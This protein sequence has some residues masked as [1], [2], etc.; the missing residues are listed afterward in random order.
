MIVDSATL[1]PPPPALPPSE[2]LAENLPRAWTD[3]TA[4]GATI[5]AQLSEKAGKPLPWVTVR[6]AIDGALRMRIVERA[7]DSGAWPCDAMGAANLK[8][9]LPTKSPVVK[10]AE[11]SPPVLVPRPGLRIASA[12]VDIGQFQDL[13]DQLSEI[14]KAAAGFDL[15]LHV[16]IEVSG[17]KPVPDQVVERINELLGQVS[18]SIKLQ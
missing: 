16:R 1:Q 3:G 17:A 15:K 10:P 13:A 6:T 9:T 14:K 18:N 12:E 5:A 8:L 2:I 7:V 4:T 11:P